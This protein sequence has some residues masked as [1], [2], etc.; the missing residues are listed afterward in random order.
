MHRPVSFAVLLL[1]FGLGAAPPAPVVPEEGLL[2]APDEAF[3]QIRRFTLVLEQ[4]RHFY[5]DADKVSYE[6]LV[7]GAL[8]GM[9]RQLDPHSQFLDRDAYHGVREDTQGEF[10]GLGMIVHIVEGALTVVSPME[11][12]PAWEAGILTDDRITDIEGLPTQGLGLPAAIDLLRGPPGSQVSFR[13]FRPSTGE[14]LPFSLTRARIESRSVRKGRMLRDGIG[15][16]RLS[17]FNEPTAKLLHEEMN[18]LAAQQA[19]ALVLDL[20]G[21]PGGLLQSAVEVA[22]VFL[23][24]GELVVFT[25]GRDEASR[26]DYASV[27]WRHYVDWPLAILVNGGSASAAEIVAGALQDHRRAVL[28]GERTFGKGSVQSLLPMEDGSAL[29][30]TTAKYFTP[31]ER[32]IHLRGIPPD[33][34]VDMSPQQ[35]ADVRR[36][37]NPD[38]SWANDPQLGR[39]VEVLHGVMLLQGQHPS[40]RR[41]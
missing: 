27:G 26:R 33:I 15:Y 12:S 11:D 5:V 40:S 28:V 10:G 18:T 31:S 21:N 41:P 32:P 38:A 34:E 3:E 6:A 1:A 20:R 16:I 13:L 9:L 35:W 4:I 29:R 7:D 25:R 24:K 2:P 37:R 14:E 8:G 17:S 39:A 22:S 36:S 19:K 23:D 30:L